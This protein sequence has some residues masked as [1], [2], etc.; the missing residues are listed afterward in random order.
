[1]EKTLLV[2]GVGGADAGHWMTWWERQE[3]GAIRADLTDPDHPV[4]AVWEFELTALILEHP[5]AIL[6]GHGLGAVTIVRILAGWPHL[7]V[8][9]VLLVA[10]CATED[11]TRIRSF[12]P[13]PEAPLAVPA[14]LV[15][16]RNDP[17]MPFDRS[18]R[19]AD[20]WGADLV[21]LGEAGHVDALAG[22]GPWPGGMA[23]RD[24]LRRR[25]ATP[26]PHPAAMQSIARM[27][28]TSAAA[29]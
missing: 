18:S 16:S 14:L 23:L 3:A 1:M 5:G 26:A 22:F 12:G 9:A 8:G 4:P 15:A 24:T 13:I 6:V 21:D 7:P 27:I 11:I 10:P 25:A 19:L 29:R 2:P 20:A 17:S 28:T